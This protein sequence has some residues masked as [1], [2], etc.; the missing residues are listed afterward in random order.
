MTDAEALM[1]QVERDPALRSSFSSVTFLDRAPDVD[2]FRQRMADGVASIPRL[3]QRVVPAPA[4]LGSPVWAEDPHFDLDYHVRHVA[5]PAPADDRHLLA[6]AALLHEDAFDPARP[7]WQFTVVEGLDRDRA[8][9]IAKMHHTISDGVGAVRMSALFIDIEPDPPARGAAAPPPAPSVGNPSLMESAGDA[10]R[11]PVD[12]GRR[13]LFGMAGAITRP[14]DVTETVWAAFRQLLVTDA[15]RSTL[16]SGLRSAG[17]RFEILSTDLG[18]AKKAAKAMGGTINDL[19]VAAIAGGAG[20][21]HREKGATVDDLRATIPVSTR[22]D[23]SAGGNAFLPTRLLV[24]AG[25]A[26]PA[27]RFRIV[28]ERMA[29]VKQ[30]RVL[31]AGDGL[32]ALVNAL[33]GPVI[34]RLARSQV[35]TVDFAASNVRGAP[36]DLYVAGAAV[37]ANHPFGPTGGTAFNATMLSYRNSMDVGLNIDTAAIDDSPLLREL[38][39]QSFEDLLVAGGA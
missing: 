23:K 18:R 27:E 37:L 3:R 8:A 14:V 29:A 24:P 10:L 31:S 12:L 4:G 25:V 15:A 13:V 21:Y 35:D 38:T 6:M 22:S 36:F 16:W 17:R 19:Y 1:W 39:A 7:L 26:D 32:A 5:L 34:T 33:P 2:R 30:D 28:H 11:R 9:L 20:A